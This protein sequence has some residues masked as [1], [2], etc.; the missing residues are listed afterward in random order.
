MLMVQRPPV[1]PVTA[2]LSKPIQAKLDFDRTGPVDPLHASHLANMPVFYKRLS[3]TRNEYIKQRHPAIKAHVNVAS[4][5]F[6]NDFPTTRP[7]VGDNLYGNP[8]QGSL[9]LF[10][11]VTRDHLVDGKAALDHPDAAGRFTVDAAGVVTIVQPKETLDTIPLGADLYWTDDKFSIGSDNMQSYRM[12]HVRVH[13][14]GVNRRHN[15]IPFGRLVEKRMKNVC[16]ARVLLYS[17]DSV[18]YQRNLQLQPNVE[19]APTDNAPTVY[20]RQDFEAEQRE[21]PVEEL[22]TTGAKFGQ[23]EAGPKTIP[24][25]VEGDMAAAPP[26]KKHKGKS[27]NSKYSS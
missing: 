16:E 14:Q 18:G 24:E 19:F 13:V 26:K 8:A 27:K 12:T 15:Q 6:A 1:T 11:G 2:L 17:N 10:L 21:A 23:A 20:D 9:L 22:A 7:R 25:P 3:N 4:P 5:Q